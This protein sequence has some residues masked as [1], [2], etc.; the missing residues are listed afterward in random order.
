MDDIVSNAE[1]R[2]Q[3]SLSRLGAAAPQCSGCGESDP[4]CLEA[5]HIAG[6]KNHD[7]TY[8]ICRNCHRK[9]SDGQRDHPPVVSSPPALR[10]IVGNYLLGLA[11]LFRVIADRLGQFGRALIAE[12]VEVP[13]NGC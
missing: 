7:E 9:L 8:P 10:E 1:I 3:R 2:R 11:D 12:I 6:R 13:A 4:R 5:H